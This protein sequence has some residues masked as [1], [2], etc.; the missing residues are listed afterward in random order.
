LKEKVKLQRAHGGYLGTQRR[1]RTRLPA[2]RF[3]ESEADNDP[4][5][6]EWGNPK[7]SSLNT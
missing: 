3:G 4:E 7:Y 6:S 2:I 1:R 5:I